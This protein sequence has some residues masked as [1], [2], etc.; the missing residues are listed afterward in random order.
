MWWSV[1]IGVAGGDTGDAVT[2]EQLERFTD[3]LEPFSASVGGGG[4]HY[5]ARLSV[6][7][8]PDQS[9]SN[10]AVE[11]FAKARDDAGLPAWPLVHLDM[12]TEEQLDAE[13]ATP[14]FP[15]VAG[16]TEAAK[17]L[18]VSKQRLIQLTD[19]PDFPA[20]MVRLA[21]GPVWL[22]SS[23]EAFERRWPRKP[24]RPAKPTKPRQ[25]SMAPAGRAARQ[26]AVAAKRASSGGYVVRDAKAGKTTRATKAGKTARKNAKQD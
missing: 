21:A 13:P 23:I 22:R 11:E 19:R 26:Y 17:M 24:G 20:P 12:M 4:N 9:A 16:V 18:G 7:V 8:T 14:T 6:D 5:S 1:Y 15:D 2:V 25:P 10:V 3:L